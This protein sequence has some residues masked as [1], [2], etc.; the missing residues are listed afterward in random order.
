MDL[1][2]FT[3][4]QRK[5]V[6]H[7]NGPLLICAGAG[8]GKTFTLT[9]RI[10]WAL[11]G[12]P[13]KGMPPFLDSIDQALVITFTN[14]AAAE[15][16][17]RFRATLRAVGRFEDALKVDGAWVCTIHGM[18]SRI[19]REHALELGID[20]EFKLAMGAVAQD[21]LMQAINAS[22]HDA[23][24]SEMLQPLF[25]EYETYGVKHMLHTIIGQASYQTRG[26][27]AF[28]LGSL[29]TNTGSFLRLAIELAEGVAATNK[30]KT[31]ERAAHA[32]EKLA[33]YQAEGADP[34]M[35]P[36]LVKSLELS[37]MRGEGATELKATLA[38][39]QDAEHLN[40]A[41][42]NMQ[43]LLHLARKVEA[44][45]QAILREQCLVDTSDLIRK[46]L[47]A[48]DEHPEVASQYTDRFK[49]I[50]VDEFQDTSQL[51]IDMI[52]RIA[53]SEKSYLCTVG[54]SQQSIY[55][56]QGADV[57]VYLKHKQ[58][59]R[60]HGALMVELQDNFRSH[61][62][63]LAFVRIVCGQPGYFVEDFLDL[64]AG[65]I[66]RRYRG[67]APRVELAVT[68]Y[69]NGCT[70]A[71][72]AQ[73]A[74]LIASRF[75]TL[76]DEGHSPSDMV[77]LMGATTR[78]EAY[79]QALRDQGIPCMASG[80][81]KYYT[82]PHV[83][84]CLSLLNVLANPFDSES[85]MD[86]LSSD[87]LPVSSSDLLQLTT[88][89]N[90]ANDGLPTRQNFAQAFLYADRMPTCASPLLQHAVNVLQRAWAKLGT[91]R[92]AS[93]FL[94]TVV[95]SGWFD[96]LAMQEEQGQA[97]IAD[98]MK[99]VRLVEDAQAEAGF[100]MARVAN[101]LHAAAESDSEAPGVLSTEGLQAVR[102]MTVHG[103]KGL[104][105]P[106]VAVTSCF[107]SRTDVGALRCVTENGTVHASLM[108]KGT[109]L[110]YEP[111]FGDDIDLT[112]SVSLAEHR[113]KIV[114][115][116]RRRAE[117]ERRRLFYVAATRATDALIVAMNKR[118]TKNMEYREIEADLLHALF[119][120]QDNF[121][122]SSGT[123]EYGGSQPATFTRIEVRKDDSLPQ[124]AVPAEAPPLV[125]ANQ[126]EQTVLIPALEEPIDLHLH[127]IPRR[128]GFYSY[129][130]IAPRDVGHSA[131]NLEPLDGQA[132]MA[133]L[134]D[135]DKATDFGSALHRT[136]EW[137]ALKMASAKQANPSAINLDI[138]GITHKN[139]YATTMR[140]AGM[141]GIRDTQRLEDAVNRWLRSSTANRDY[142]FAVCQPEV[143]FCTHIASGY[144]EGEID[145]LCYSDHEHAFIVDY[146]TGGNEA[147]TPEQL[148]AKHLLQAQCY[149]YATLTSG[150]QS[151]EL[152]FVRVERPRSGADDEPQVVSYGF[153]VEDLPVLEAAIAAAKR[154]AL[155]R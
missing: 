53:G 79:A 153:N 152:H 85:M 84:R 132:S 88:Y 146:K 87:V 15:L 42:N 44:H 27:D 149:A 105:F 95:E 127:P 142:R 147:E 31:A 129:S 111:D 32:A 10:A 119:P 93:L 16:K 89:C 40:L 139:V 103:S 97:I 137:I 81:S 46:T 72:V 100:D 6:Q 50:M 1:S 148:Q 138:A 126:G 135:T 55:R 112:R 29:P 133:P 80:G 75:R 36:D 124:E 7:L 28:D 77:V 117:A 78:M 30:G 38:M 41:W 90:P 39:L 145:L 128:V 34:H 64:H 125:I 94:E 143:P 120:R 82:A 67:S 22:I 122:E 66:G 21:A 54:D 52:E 59:M 110:G 45:Y 43:L 155:D 65:S 73:E 96:R 113:A 151:V 83:Q 108:P 150:F 18:C 51:Q 56:F 123:F 76:I 86:V 102:L 62:D 134:P 26:L 104:E 91:V 60:A 131:S 109:K 8:T 61:A 115:V 48:F 4:D 49:L 20:P 106:I 23:N 141:H 68:L 140:F 11:V 121:P 3:P 24:D 14:K 12:S 33:N 71:A 57:S 19:L 25:A 136:C 70:D 99:M 98:I 114:E 47:A 101:A 154:A 118:I 63:I 37:R 5:A 107:T 13:D 9:Q 116:D 58:D 92:P 144:L 74:H 17:G 130:S 35:L 2:S 69:E